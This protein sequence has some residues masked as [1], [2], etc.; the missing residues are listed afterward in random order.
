MGDESRAGV[1]RERLGADAADAL[2]AGDDRITFDLWAANAT[3]LAD[4]GVRAVE[5]AG[6]CTRCGGADLWSYR[7][8]AER[9][10]Q[11]TALAVLGR[12]G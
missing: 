2:Q 7:S 9:G 6:I 11:G 4:A 1:I 8:R 12:P 5:V 3:Q 10:P